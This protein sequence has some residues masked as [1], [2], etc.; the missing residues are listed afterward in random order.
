MSVGSEKWDKYL[1]ALNQECFYFSG[2]NCSR[3]FFLLHS[4]YLIILFFLK[5]KIKLTADNLTLSFFTTFAKKPPHFIPYNM[6]HIRK[7]RQPFE[8]YHTSSWGRHN[9]VDTP[10][11]PP[12]F[13]GKIQPNSTFNK[14]KKSPLVKFCFIYRGFT[15][16]PKYHGTY[17]LHM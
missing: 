14:G 17:E 15:P 5:N 10:P 9:M 2:R 16:S 6:V 11:T 4:K 8:L 3:Q 1:S 13:Q 7:H 12:I